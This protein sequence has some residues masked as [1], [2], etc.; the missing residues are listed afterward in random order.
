MTRGLVGRFLYFVDSETAGGSTISPVLRRAAVAG[1]GTPDSGFLIRLP[2]L[3]G[4]FPAVDG[5]TQ[6]KASTAGDDAMFLLT[7]GNPVNVPSFG[8]G[9]RSNVW[10]TTRTSAASDKTVVEYFNRD[11]N[12][13]FITGRASEQATL[14]ALPASFQRTGMRF[15]AKSS[16]YRDV[17]ELPVCRFYAAPE[18]GGSNTHFYGAGDDCPALNTVR[19]VR[20]EGFDFAAIKPT[21][22]ACP[23]TAPNPVYRLFNNQSAINQGNHRYV[24]SAAT[25]SRMIAQ[26]WLDEG[27]V[28]CAT[29]AVDAAN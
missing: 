11:V 29:S 15:S 18:S 13:Y 25:K 19:Q 4:S 9:S 14:D 6:D 2:A 8:G 12:R 3:G 24:V 7:Y 10:A 26:G 16:E 5:I 27:V 28:F 21:N 17:P 22:A 23:T 20:F 1:S